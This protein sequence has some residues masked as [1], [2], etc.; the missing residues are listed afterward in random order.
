ME[1]ET[2]VNGQTRDIQLC[3]LE[4]RSI[5]NCN[6]ERKVLLCLG[7]GVS[8]NPGHKCRIDPFYPILHENFVAFRF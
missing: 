5:W 4:N 1:V 2:V 6:Q 7:S 8:H 3:F